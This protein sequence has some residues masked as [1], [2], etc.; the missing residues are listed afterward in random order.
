MVQDDRKT[1]YFE[2]A[3]F[4]DDYWMITCLVKLLLHLKRGELL[5]CL[6]RACLFP[7]E[8]LGKWNSR[9]VI[10][11]GFSRFGQEDWWSLRFSWLL[12]T[13]VNNLIFSSSR[14]LRVTFIVE[15]GSHDFSH[16]PPHAWLKNVKRMEK[17]LF[18]SKYWP[19]MNT[20][21]L[22]FIDQTGCTLITGYIVWKYAQFIH[23]SVRFNTRRLQRAPLT[24]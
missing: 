14:A 9:F 22:T 3:V 4:W 16:E 7:T 2:S 12:S 18:I 20:D 21:E 19:T 15:A 5:P 1:F 13:S 6:W 8:L 17:V 23:E 11:S 24:Y 10:P